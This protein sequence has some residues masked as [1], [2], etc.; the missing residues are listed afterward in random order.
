MA[1]RYAA[2]TDVSSD[3]SKAE[4]ERV[5]ARYGAT[6]FGYLSEPDAVQI[7]F[8]MQGR[9]F[10]Y[11]LPM[12]NREDPAI[13]TYRQGSSTY[14]RV[15]TEIDKRYEQAIR[16]RW[17]A[18]LLVVKAKLEGVELGIV[19]LEDEFLA[20]TVMTSGET[21]GEWARPQLKEMYLTGGMPA[22]MLG[23]GR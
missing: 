4:L 20:A 19:S 10:K 12:P 15:E 16:Q 11:R 17:R 13:C 18:L 7:A 14:R 22:L 21:V 6:R 2:Q 8:E 9:R 3:R 5:L 23:P 1:G